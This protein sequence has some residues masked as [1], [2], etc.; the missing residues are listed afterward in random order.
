MTW[1]KQRERGKE[2]SREGGN[3]REVK[4][5]E[6]VKMNINGKHDY[7]ILATYITFCTTNQKR[8]KRCRKRGLNFSSQDRT[9]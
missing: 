5:E 7:E 6:K 2:G 4:K 1:K 3:E 9:H 8:N